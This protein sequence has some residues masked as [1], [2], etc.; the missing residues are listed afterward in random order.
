MAKPFTNTQSAT[1]LADLVGIVRRQPTHFF[2]KPALAAGPQ[3]GACFRLPGLGKPRS[4]DH[5]VH[6]G[7]SLATGHAVKIKARPAVKFRVVVA[8]KAALLGTKSK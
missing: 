8:I 5:K 7:R 2:H 3:A 6:T 4:A 1:A